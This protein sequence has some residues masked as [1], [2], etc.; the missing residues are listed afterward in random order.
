MS[1]PKKP[2]KTH[3]ISHIC[4]QHYFGKRDFVDYLVFWVINLQVILKEN[5]QA[6]WRLD[7]IQQMNV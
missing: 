7:A 1:D 2:Y 5:C 3:Q 6:T 4:E